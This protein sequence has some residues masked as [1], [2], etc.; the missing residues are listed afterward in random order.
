MKTK[1]LP[2][3]T[4][5]FKKLISNGCY[6]V[7]KTLLIKELLDKNNEVTLF[8]RPRRFGKTLN[9]S[10]LRY[11]FEDTGDFEKN[12][13]NQEL[14]RGLGIMGCG[15]KYL[16]HMGKY[17]VIQL[18]LKSA[19]QSTWDLSFLMIKRQ[20]AAEF[21]RHSYVAEILE[22]NH[23]ERFCT[24]QQEKGEL[25]DYLDAVAF[26]SRCLEKYHHTQ[27]VIL[28]D[29]YDVPLENAYFG[30]FYKEMV[31]FI[32]SLF[33]TA[34]KGNPSLYF[35]VITGCLRITKESIFTG[36]NNLKIKSILSEDYGE[37]FG[38]TPEET[39]ALLCD[40]DRDAAFP[41]VRDW[42]D[43]YLFGNREMY[44]PWSLLNYVDDLAANPDAF[45]SPYW[46][47]TS[48]NSI[49]QELV[50]ASDDNVQE[51]IE[52][53]IAGHTIQKPIHEDVTYEDIHSSQDNL[54]NFLFFTGY[55]TQA[56]GNLDGD[57][58]YVELAIPNRE[59]CYIYKNTVRRWFDR[60]LLSADLTP[61]FKA[62]ENGD[63]DAA[64]A[65]ISRELQE[66]ISFFD[67]AENYY[68]GFL[69]GILKNMKGYK[70]TTN[71]EAGLGRADIIL[72]TPSIHGRAFVLELKVA[73]SIQEM[74][75]KCDEAL[76]QIITK[77]YDMPLKNDG[78]EEVICYGVSF[79]QKECLVKKM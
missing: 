11:F 70:I 63:T 6:Y 2:I 74:E 16:S 39:S 17:P 44:N 72:R 9:I 24:I 76:Q 50:E 30:G 10:M 21:E 53:L 32:R 8:T 3:G 42:Y 5:D 27:S 7:D 13:E 36:L 66:T 64:S 22:P 20:L 60:K 31:Y 26:L 29:E 41:T 14:F 23:R 1:P 57:T 71:R 65:C 40:Y 45:P 46:S 15:E 62:L 79:Y 56:G 33:E 78:Y 59:V 55:L 47:N 28:I 35:A 49:V 67:Y 48:S 77:Q 68:H 25:G 4:D 75:K 43:G 34:L 61:L 12:K 73:S 38:F 58:Q 18:S 54:W 37:Y 51:E 19:K 69:A 52:Q